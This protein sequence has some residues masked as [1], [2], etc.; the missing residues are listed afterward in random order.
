MNV[1]PEIGVLIPD[2]EDFSDWESAVIYGGGTPKLIHETDDLPNSAQGLLVG[3]TSQFKN[4][5]HFSLINALRQ[6]LPVL[7]IH[8]GMHVLNRSLGG[9]REIPVDSDESKIK[10]SVFLAPGGKISFIIAGSGWV[11]VPFSNDAGIRQL[12]LS[13]E[14]FA[15]SYREDGFLVGIEMPGRRWVMGIQWD[16]QKITEMPKGFDSLLM[17]FCEEAENHTLS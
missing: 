17:A 12:Q 3:G 5:L 1:R 13:P 14:L 10:Q 15:S 6:N 7:G 2:G 8:N 4:D 16:A 11:S 9:F